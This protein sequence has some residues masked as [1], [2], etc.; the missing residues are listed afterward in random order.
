MVDQQVR[1][2]D[3]LDT[4]VLDTLAAVPRERFVPGPLRSVAHADGPIPLAHGQSILAPKLD[5]K[6]LQALDVSPGERV[7]EVGTGSGYFAACLRALGAQVTSLEIHPDLASLAR[8]NL[9]DAGFTGIELLEADATTWSPADAFDVVVLTA[10]LPVY[11]ARFEGWLT[12]SGRLFVVVGEGEPMS[13][14]IVRRSPGGIARTTLF[15]TSI[16]P[17]IHARRGSHF[18]F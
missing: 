11:D 5:G 12:A 8:S 16:D 15:E 1:T 18:S 3:V 13:A 14:Q 9:H 4:R 10:S 2:W 7:L 6:I 17:L